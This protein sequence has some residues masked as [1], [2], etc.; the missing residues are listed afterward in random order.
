MIDRRVI[1]LFEIE[2]DRLKK[3][4]TEKKVNK[5]FKKAGIGYRL[6][7]DTSKVAS[8]RPGTMQQNAQSQVITSHISLHSNIVFEVCARRVWVCFI[9]ILIIEYGLRANL[10]GSW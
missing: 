8:V 7:D 10:I 2:M 3:F 4:L 1:F 5:N 9:F 6:T